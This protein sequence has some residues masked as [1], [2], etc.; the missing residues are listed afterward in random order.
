M[1]PIDNFYHPV[2]SDKGYTLFHSRR[3]IIVVR[4]Q[5]VKRPGI[6]DGVEFVHKT[7]HAQ[8]FRKIFNMPGLT[9][10]T[11]TVEAT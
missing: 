7:S 8:C 2:P 10:C 6:F 3:E 11:P 5:W 1:R 9:V 4:E